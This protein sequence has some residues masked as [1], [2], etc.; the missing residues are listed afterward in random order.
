MTSRRSPRAF[1]TITF[2]WIVEIDLFPS[3]ASPPRRLLSLSPPSFLPPAFSP[4][5]VT[6]RFHL[7][8]LLNRG[9]VSL[10]RRLSR[11]PVTRA[12]VRTDGRK[13]GNPEKDDQDDCQ[14]QTGKRRRRLG[15]QREDNAVSNVRGITM[16]PLEANGPSARV[17]FARRN[18]PRA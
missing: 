16:S 4:P 7:F 15:V 9:K 1:R 8:A 18:L 12:R 5:T 13:R 2:Y 10:K 3:P 14:R 6:G 17:R 11:L